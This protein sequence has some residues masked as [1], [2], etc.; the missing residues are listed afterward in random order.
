[1]NSPD[2]S[3]QTRFDNASEAAVVAVMIAGARLVQR[4]EDVCRVHGITHDQYNLLR[5]LRGAHPDGHPRFEISK[6]LISRSPDVTRLIDRLERSG[7]T[8]RT[9][10]R[11]N[12]SHSIARI[13]DAGLELLEQIDPGIA[14]VQREVTGDV[15]EE[16]LRALSRVCRMLRL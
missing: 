12:R 13:T 10:S 7:L 1:M 16:D 6:R 4:F 11:E 14:E 5:I 3:N 9:W 8:E 2:K 15:N